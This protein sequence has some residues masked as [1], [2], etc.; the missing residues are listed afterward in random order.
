MNV[1]S[2]NSNIF[3]KKKKKRVM[4]IVLTVMRHEIKKISL[5]AWNLN[6]KRHS[7]YSMNNDLFFGPCIVDVP[8]SH[9]KLDSSSWKVS[10]SKW[11]GISLLFVF[12]DSFNLWRSLLIIV[13]WSPW[14]YILYKFKENIN[15]FLPDIYL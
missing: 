8:K 6:K 11:N 13:I 1:L 2:L 3:I 9:W 14:V 10:I 4:S 7:W 15:A 12:R 5:T